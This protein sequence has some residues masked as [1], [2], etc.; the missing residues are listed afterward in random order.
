[1][2]QSVMARYRSGTLGLSI[3]GEIG[4]ALSRLGERVGSQRMI[5]NPWTY[6]R[7]HRCSMDTA[8]VMVAGILD[9]YPDLRSAVDLG[10]GTGVYVSEFR[11]R[12]VSSEGYE[13]SK[14]ARNIATRR[15]GLDLQPFDLQTF[16]GVPAEFDLCTCFEVAEHLTPAMGE[17][18]V[19]ICAQSAS[20][21]VF[22]AAHPGQGGQGHINEQPKSYWVEKFKQH[23]FQLNESASR[24]LVDH[25]RHKLRRGFWL[26][27][28]VVVLERQEA[29]DFAENK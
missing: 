9:C 20:R 8:P 25:L 6:L 4:G 22:S 21:V 17:R 7:F 10:C 26:A 3:K 29:A 11:K 5:Y 15:L 1:M 23:D 2:S 24:Q 19:E 27:D 28:N 12:D 14:T 16:A 13:Y 18:L